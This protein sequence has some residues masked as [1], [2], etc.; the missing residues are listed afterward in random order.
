MLRRVSYANKISIYVTPCMSIR[1][2][3]GFLALK[4]AVVKRREGN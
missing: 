4:I 3:W 1:K 2:I